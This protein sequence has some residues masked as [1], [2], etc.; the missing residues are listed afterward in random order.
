MIMSAVQYATYYMPK[1]D[2]KYNLRKDF[3]R[4]KNTLP[5]LKPLS[6]PIFPT[7]TKFINDHAAV[8]FQK[9]NSYILPWFYKKRW[10]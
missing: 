7:S 8:F 5:I 3:E 10:R 2:K 6:F 4:T 1:K 9:F